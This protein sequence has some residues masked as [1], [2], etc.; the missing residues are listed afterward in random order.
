MTGQKGEAFDAFCKF[1]EF[2]SA[3]EQYRTMIEEQ[4]RKLG[5]AQMAENLRRW[6]RG[7]RC[8]QSFL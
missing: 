8:P 4:I 2:G 1:L 7:I 6:C 5:E 3:P